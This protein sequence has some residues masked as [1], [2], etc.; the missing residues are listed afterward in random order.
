ML[1]PRLLP[2]NHRM[3]CVYRQDAA[4]QAQGTEMVRSRCTCGLLRRAPKP[5]KPVDDAPPP[6]TIP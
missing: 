1:D 5:E 3:D 2:E 4:K 6:T